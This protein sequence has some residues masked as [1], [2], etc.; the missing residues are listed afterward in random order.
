MNFSLLDRRPIIVAI[1]GP[2]GAGKTTFFKSFLATTGLR[3]LNADLL[4]AD[5]NVNPYSAAEIVEALRTAL[6]ARRESFM[7]ETVFS[8]PIAAKISFLK[9]ASDSGYAVIVCFIG[10]SDSSQSRQRVAMRVSKGG[11]DV[12]GEKIELRFPRVLQ[13]LRLAIQQLPHVL[14]YDNSD[15]NQPYRH[16]AEFEN[17]NTIALHQP[18]PDWLRHL[19]P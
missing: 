2:N 4:G 15:L 12:P 17:G 5:L 14:V 3:Y 7:F 6:V 19:V 13:N 8:D 9:A 1:A 11:H 18:I 10:L 16:V